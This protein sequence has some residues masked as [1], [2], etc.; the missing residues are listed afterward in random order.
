MFSS[1]SCLIVFV[2]KPI[3]CSLPVV[4]GA[5]P[6]SVPISNCYF[7]AYHQIV[8]IPISKNRNYLEEFASLVVFLVDNFRKFPKK[9]ENVTVWW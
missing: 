7:S 5:V 2:L 3:S 1:C 4:S 9:S 6:V 8:A